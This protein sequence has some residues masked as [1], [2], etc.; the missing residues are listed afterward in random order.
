MVCSAWGSG[1]GWMNTVLIIARMKR[2]S[3][4]KQQES[5][6]FLDDKMTFAGGTKL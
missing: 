4:E 1:Y 5:V 2:D 6:E 3:N